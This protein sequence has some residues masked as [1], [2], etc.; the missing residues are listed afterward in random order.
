MEL[1]LNLYFDVSVR[2][3][4]ILTISMDQI[5]SQKANNWSTGQEISCFLWNPKMFIYH[6]HKSSLLVPILNLI[7]P[8]HFTTCHI[9]KIHFSIFHHQYLCIGG[10]VS[11]SWN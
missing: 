4:V 7:T 9:S 11:R 5:L 6:V 1:G 2:R 3:S 10:N 8:V